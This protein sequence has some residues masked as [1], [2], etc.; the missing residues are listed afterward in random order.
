MAQ[1]Y[2]YLSNITDPVYH[3][4]NSRFSNR[5]YT[6]ALVSTQEILVMKTPMFSDVTLC[7][8]VDTEQCSEQTCSIHLHTLMKK[9]AG[10]SEML[11]NIYHTT[12]TF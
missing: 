9:V 11:V 4:I 7:S 10:S 1:L 2:V 12:A 5:K 8:L 3:Y 6:P